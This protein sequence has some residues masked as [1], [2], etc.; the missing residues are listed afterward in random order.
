[1]VAGAPWLGWVAASLGL[2]AALDLGTITVVSLFGAEHSVPGFIGQMIINLVWVWPLH[3]GAL[4]LATLF[5][6]M[7]RT[8]A[9]A[10][11][12]VFRLT[13]LALFVGPAIMITLWLTHGDPVPLI[14]VLP[15]HVL[16]A[17]LVVR[18]RVVPRSQ[19][20]S[21]DQHDW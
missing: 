8:V 14:G 9:D 13:A 15:M 17:L 18:P 7:L 19:D 5:L 10:G 6:T 1:M 16:M 11:C 21:M 3:L 2:Y 20:P 12:F 4:L